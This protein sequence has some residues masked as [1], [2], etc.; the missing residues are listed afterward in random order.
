[1]N[2][3]TGRTK[4]IPTQFGTEKPWLAK[5]AARG[6]WLLLILLVAGCASPGTQPAGPADLAAVITELSPAVDRTEAKT[7]AKTALET[8][9]ELVHEYRAVRPAILQ[10]CLVNVGLRERGL[11]YHWADDLGARL[12]ALQLTS[13]DIHSG[14]ARVGSFREHNAVVVTARGK[15]FATGVV[16][17]AWRHSGRLYWGHVASDKYPWLPAPPTLDA[18][19]DNLSP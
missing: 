17:D 12:R 5:V 16:L 3:K 10:N 13:L 8:A 19:L 4:A 11:C 9:S 6:T 18:H 2:E 7:L 1:M 14:A 15:P